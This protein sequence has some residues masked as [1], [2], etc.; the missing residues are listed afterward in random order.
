MTNNITTNIIIMYS[1]LHRFFFQCFM[2][3]HVTCM[4]MYVRT[5]TKIK[6]KESLNS[7]QSLSWRKPEQHGWL[8][9]LNLVEEK[10]K[11]KFQVKT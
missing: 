2:V 8:V 6:K 4:C 5:K 7:F 11:K 3:D 1:V 10:T 9:S